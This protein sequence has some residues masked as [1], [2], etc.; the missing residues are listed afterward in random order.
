MTKDW[1]SWDDLAPE[2]FEKYP[3]WQMAL[4]LEE[5][6]ESAVR[7][8][9]KLPVDDLAT[10]VVGSKV[11]LAN[12]ERLWAT[13]QNIF[14]KNPHKTRH[15]L[16]LSLRHDGH[17]VPLDRYHDVCLRLFGPEPLAKKLGLPLNQVF[18]IAYDVRSCVVGDPLALRGI[19]EA[20]PKDKL[21][22]EEIFQLIVGK[23]PNA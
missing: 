17:W 8:V 15:L 6:D 12:G 7:P 13:I 22:R 5:I 21:S 14:P 4:D 2:D 10:R 11:R 16:S 3:V 19:I 20:D 9:T 23:N 18:P 1:K